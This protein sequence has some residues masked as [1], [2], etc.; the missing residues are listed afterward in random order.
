MPKYFSFDK[1]IGCLLGVNFERHTLSY[2][3]FILKIKNTFPILDIWC[4]FDR[5]TT[6][7]LENCQN[8]MSFFVNPVL[9]KMAS[10]KTNKNKNQTSLLKTNFSWLETLS[11]GLKRLLHS[12]GPKNAIHLWVRLRKFNGIEQC[13]FDIVQ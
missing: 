5:Q 8:P 10:V 4:I 2:G 1:K 3:N 11:F 6:F 9:S 7:H 13:R 12:K